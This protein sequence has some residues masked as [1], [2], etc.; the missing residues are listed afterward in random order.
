MNLKD[1]KKENT[2][3]KVNSSRLYQKNARKANVFGFPFV[4]FK[5]KINLKEN[6]YEIK[7]KELF[8][9]YKNLLIKFDNLENFKDEIELYYINEI[10]NKNLIISNL[11]E[12]RDSKYKRRITGAK[13]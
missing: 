3:S 5:K 1:N 13:K 2:R 8:E 6:T 4:M 12:E 7:Y 11:K 9:R 10:K